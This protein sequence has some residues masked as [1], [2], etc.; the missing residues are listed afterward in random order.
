MERERAR[1]RE[2]PARGEDGRSP[3]REA[4][5]RE[6][7][8]S[9]LDALKRLHPNI[10]ADRPSAIDAAWAALTATERRTAHDRHGAWLADCK[11]AGR[12]KGVA[13]S[14]YLREK[15]WT[16]LSS[17]KAPAGGEL[18]RTS[19]M[20]PA[21]SRL[22]WCLLFSLIEA[23]RATIGDPRSPAAAGLRRQVSLAE[24][25]IGWKCDPARIADFER[26]A[27]GFV[28]VPRDGTEAAAWSAWLRGRAG[29]SLPLPDSAG[30]IYVPA[31]APP[32]TG[33]DGLSASELEGLG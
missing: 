30:W 24:K 19:G 11:A 6:A 8:I 23:E 1:D 20:V 18:W 10:S 13:L 21:W 22:W 32:A 27:A 4:S 33:M 15:P 5:D 3:D 31:S 14:T 12:S 28:G 16:L 26:S 17:A 7:N 9:L 29:V 25:S 2:N